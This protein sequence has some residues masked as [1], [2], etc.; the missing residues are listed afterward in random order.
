LCFPWLDEIQKNCLVALEL[1]EILFEFR[2]KMEKD[3]TV[4]EKLVSSYRVEERT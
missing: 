2:K 3:G 4:I 1:E